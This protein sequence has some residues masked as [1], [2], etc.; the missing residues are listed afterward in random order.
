LVTKNLADILAD[1]VAFNGANIDASISS[2]SSAL[3]LAVHDVDI[4]TLLGTLAQ[5]SDITLSSLARSLAI[6]NETTKVGAF[7][8]ADKNNPTTNEQALLTAL[9]KEF[10][11]DLVDDDDVA[12][13]KMDFTA[14]SA[15]VVGDSGDVAKLSNLAD[16]AV[17][18]IFTKGEHAATIGKMAT[19]GVGNY[20]TSAGTQC[21]VTSTSHPTVLSE[22]LG[23]HDIY[24]TSGNFG[25]LLST[26]LASGVGVFANIQGEPTHVGLAI[27]PIDGINSDSLASPEIRYFFGA[28]EPSKYTDHTWE[29]V[30]WIA[31]WVVHQIALVTLVTSLEKSKT[32]EEML[33]KG[34]FVKT[35][36]VYDYLVH[37]TTGSA[38]FEVITEYES[39]SVME[40]LE[41]IKN[42]LRRGTGT[43]LP[44][45]KSLYDVIAL[46]R[47]DHA[48]YGLAALN[49]DLDTL[50]LRLGD[51]SPSTIKALIDS[52]QAKLDNGTY[53]LAALNADLDAVKAKTDLIPAD[54]S[55]Q[56]DTNIPAI[57]TQT[58]KIP[59]ILCHMDFWSDN[60]DEIVLTTT[61]GA[62]HN[63]PNCVVAGLPAGI[64]IIR[65]VALLKIALIKDTSGADNAING[66]T[67]LKVDASSLYDSLVTAIDIPD[68]SWAVDVSEATERGGDVMIGDNDIKTEVTGN[69]TYYGQLTDIVC[70]GNNLKLKD[71]AWGLRIYFTV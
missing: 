36:S 55:T 64:T 2:R 4:K 62:D 29:H 20:G 7:V 35:R 60:D 43:I 25:W 67:S 57:K 68:N 70:D 5:P 16:L 63:L 66:A 26:A 61:A 31:D 41:W 52:I 12:D 53:G 21:N 30:A 56:L 9:R 51:P 22:A 46:D 59:R 37:G 54:I 71:V 45:N 1:S 3:A 15:I 18:L 8:V 48:T 32:I 23:V 50:I 13:A 69:A 42:A 6:W 38:P 49:T 33:G 14:Y 28:Q 47:L 58:D 65:V 39:R 11:I 34:N 44:T 19:V 24:T 27:L 10:H 40:R 17:P